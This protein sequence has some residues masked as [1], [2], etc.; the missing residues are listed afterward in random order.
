MIATRQININVDDVTALLFEKAPD[1]KKNSLNYLLKLWLN[2][3]TNKD[4]LSIL[5]DRIGF[6]A[7]ANGLTEEKLNK[8]I[9]ED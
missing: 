9:N 2:D 1:Y 3:E 6:Q 4:S 5:M 7:L 8:I